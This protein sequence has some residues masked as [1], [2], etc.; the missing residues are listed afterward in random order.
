MSET[1]AKRTIVARAC[2]DEIVAASNY[3]RNVGGDDLAGR[4]AHDLFLAI[5]KIAN[6]PLTGL[7][8]YDAPR[9]WRHKKTGKFP[10]DFFYSFDE[11]DG[12]LYIYL[13]RHQKQ[14]PY[15]PDELADIASERESDVVD[16]DF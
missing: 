15:S 10:Y 9:G 7:P 14:Q 2:R 16:F 13:L 1:K 8:I 3:Y 11:D 4:C 12:T 6:S 5:H